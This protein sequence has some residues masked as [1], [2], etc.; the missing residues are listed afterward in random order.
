MLSYG[1]LGYWAYPSQGSAARCHTLPSGILTIFGLVSLSR[2]GHLHTQYLL[3]FL[4]PP[5]Q[6]SAFSPGCTVDLCRS[7]RVT[8][9]ESTSSKRGK[10]KQY[11][12][13]TSENNS[14]PAFSTSGSF[15]SSSHCLCFFLATF[16]AFFGV[17]VR[18]SLADS[19]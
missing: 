13:N 16:R 9:Q 4:T 10:D 11:R 7:L 6:S 18:L 19:L 3:Q 15:L 5:A 8:C 14:N 2:S 1:A 17:T 12:S